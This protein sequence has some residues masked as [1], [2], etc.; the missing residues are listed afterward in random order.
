MFLMIPAGQLMP[1]TKG[2][3]GGWQNLFLIIAQSL[4]PWA[5]LFGESVLA[6]DVGLKNASN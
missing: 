4:A 5:D 2:H 6:K 3:S 1:G